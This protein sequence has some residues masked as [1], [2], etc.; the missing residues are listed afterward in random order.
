MLSISQPH[1]AGHLLPTS[2][3]LPHHDPAGLVQGLKS[4]AVFVPLGISA[5]VASASHW[6]GGIHLYT[7]LEERI[8]FQ[9]G[10]GGENGGRNQQ[11]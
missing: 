6:R 9:E 10:T 1:P 7:R 8:E 5:L 11:V 2:S 4:P 3:H